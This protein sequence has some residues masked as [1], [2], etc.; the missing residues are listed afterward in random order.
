MSH[1]IRVIIFIHWVGVAVWDHWFQVTSSPRP[2]KAL[3][4]LESFISPNI[5]SHDTDL[6]IMGILLLNLSHSLSNK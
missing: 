3:S 6:R 1:W 4:N 5:R 2:E